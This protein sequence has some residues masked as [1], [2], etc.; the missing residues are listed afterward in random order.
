MSFIMMITLT[1]AKSQLMNSPVVFLLVDNI[2][3]RLS[4]EQ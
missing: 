3:Y 4:H 2:Q 1:S